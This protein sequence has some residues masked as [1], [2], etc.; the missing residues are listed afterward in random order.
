MNLPNK[1]TVLRF[2]LTIVFVAMSTVPPDKQ[3]N[4]LVWK[5][6]F[7]LAI[8][9]GFTDFLDGY[10]ARKHNLVTDFG[11][12]MDP[13]TDKVFTLG[14]FIVLVGHDLMPAWVVIALLAREFG[15]TG[16]RSVAASK[17]RVI[18]AANVGK[19]KTVMQMGLL[20]IGG[21]IWV[22]WLPQNFWYWDVPMYVVVVYT[23]YTGVVYFRANSDLYMGE[24]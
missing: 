24:M 4:L 20:A 11:K 15:V 23:V 22:Q 5:I 3:T 21:A 12:L 9:A 13:L 7:A 14:C 19:A 10:L 16:L 18:A 2:I 6:A 8:V 1:L 17:G